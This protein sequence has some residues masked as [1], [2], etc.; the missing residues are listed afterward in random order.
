MR[1]IL[2]ST[3]ILLGLLASCKQEPTFRI[4]GTMNN[5]SCDSA[6]IFLVPAEGPQT[7]E[8][9]DSILIIDGKFYFEGTKEQVSILRLEMKHRMNYQDLLVITEPGDIHVFYSDKGKTAGTPQN[10]HLQQWKEALEKADS[11]I[12]PLRTKWYETKNSEDSIVYFDT[13]KREREILGERTKELITNEGQTT[14]GRFLYSR[15]R[16][17]F[18]DSQKATLDS[19]YNQY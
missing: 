7:S 18:D 2:L 13:M 19:L 8:T 15:N 17:V 14:L 4:Y 11:S 16:S 5:N 3:A 6:K 9:V 10:E 12:A 1:K